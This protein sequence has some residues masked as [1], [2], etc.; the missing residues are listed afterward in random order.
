VFIKVLAGAA[1]IVTAIVIA[2][3][4]GLLFYV[5]PTGFHDQQ[6][7][8]TPEVLQRLRSLN[9]SINSAPIPPP[10]ILGRCMKANG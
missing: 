6:L 7:A 5:W 3:V 10:S 1:A 2:G 8:I 9:Q 4:S